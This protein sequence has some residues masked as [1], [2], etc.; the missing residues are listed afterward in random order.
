MDTHTDT[1]RPGQQHYCLFDT[2]IG[3]FAVAWSERGLTRLQLPESDRDAA[4]QR[5]RRLV[6]GRGRGP[7]TPP[8]AISQLFKNLQRYLAGNKT[9]FLS[10]I[11]DLR[12]TSPFHRR[13]Y[14]AARSVGWGETATYGEIARK[15]RAPAAARAV[16]SA[17]SRNPIAIII[18]CHRIL[19]RGQKI[20]GFSAH[21]GTAAKARLLALEG[22]HVAVAANGADED[23]LF[24]TR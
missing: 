6:G 11:I 16:G 24:R 21:G 2:A 1:A 15:T 7:E 20:G 4:E 8:P 10:V 19:A 18:P 5:I 14:E 23:G 17:L 9:E 13:V 3:T 12:M 22:V